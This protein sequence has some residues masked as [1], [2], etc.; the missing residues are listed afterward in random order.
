MT[1]DTINRFL[2]EKIKE[3]TFAEVQL[4]EKIVTT[5]IL[6]SINLV[7]L[8]VSIEEEY[9]V[10]IQTGDVT[11]ENVDTINRLSNFILRKLNK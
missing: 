4:D 7:D 11:E 6:D 8:T 9:G 5:R 3:L 1:K 10:V 2:F